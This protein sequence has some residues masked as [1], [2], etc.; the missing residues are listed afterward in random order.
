MRVK[1]HETVITKYAVSIIRKKIVIL[2]QNKAQISYLITIIRTQ[3]V[4][5]NADEYNILL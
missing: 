1:K 5:K 3:A 2:I 4:R